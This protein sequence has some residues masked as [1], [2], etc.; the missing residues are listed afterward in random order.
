MKNQCQIFMS[1]CQVSMSSSVKINK[2]ILDNCLITDTLTAEKP[3]QWS[4]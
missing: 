4:E 3:R 2:S 1:H